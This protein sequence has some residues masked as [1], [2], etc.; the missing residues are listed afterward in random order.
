MAKQLNVNLAFTADTGKAAASIRSLQNQLT[1]LMNNAAK[2][3]A[4]LGLTKDI[5]EA[6]TA[7]AQLK[8]QL[9]GAMSSTGTLD[10]T[11][12]NDSLRASGMT[13]EQYRVK[14]SALGPEGTAAFSQLASSVASAEIPI[15][16]ANTLLTELGTTLA[17]TARWQLSSSLLHGFIGGLQHAY[18]YAQD[19][20]ES[21]NNI[22]IVTGQSTEQMA[23]LAQKAN[24]AAKELSTR[25]TDYTNASLI[26]YQQGLDDKAVEERTRTTLKLANVTRQSAEE[27]SSQ[28]TAIWN[29]F[30]DGSKKLEYYADAITALGAKTA[31]SSS[32]IAQGLS[33]FAAVADTIGL[34]YETASAAIATVVAE[35]RQSADTVGNAFK[36]IFARIESL[37]LGETLEDGVGLTKYTEALEK[38]GVQVLDMNG[39]L[40]DADSILSDLGERWNEISDT[41]KVAL[42]NT[43]AGQ[44][45]Y[46]QFVALFD[47]WDKVQ[48]NMGIVEDS[49]GTLQNQADIYAES[50]EASSKRVKASAEAIYDALLDDNFFIEFNNLLSEILDQ[51]NRLIKG[52]GG[53]GGTLTTLGALLTKVF[54]QQ[55]ASNIDRIVNNLTGASVKGAQQQQQEAIL[56]LQKQA[57][58]ARKSGSAQGFAQSE[59]LKAQA[60]LQETLIKNQAR[61]NEEQLKT[62]QNLLDQNNSLRQAADAQGELLDKT[63]K[64][65]DM[66]MKQTHAK[67]QLQ[68]QANGKNI[69]GIQIASLTDQETNLR[70]LINTIGQVE[71]E[72]NSFY[73]IIQNKSS[74]TN[75][76]IAEMGEMWNKNS[77][78]ISHLLGEAKVGS[79]AI[80]ELGQA[81]WSLDT[82]EASLIR[83]K[84][85]L[86]EVATQ[87]AQNSSNSVQD[88]AQSYTLLCG[89][90]DKAIVLVEELI[91]QFNKEE[92]V[93]TKLKEVLESLKNSTDGAADAMN[94]MKTQS[95]TFGQQVQA[96]SQFAMSFASVI[97]S[98]KS[99]IN[100]LN[101][102]DLS[103]GEKLLTIIPSLTM[104][105]SM[106]TASLTGTTGAALVTAASHI[107]LAGIFAANTV[108]AEGF[109]AA[110]LTLGS[111]LLAL[112]LPIAAIVGVGAGLIALFQYLSSNTPEAKLKAAKEA[113]EE[114]KTSL[115][116]AKTAAEDLQSAFDNYQSVRTELDNCTKGTDEWREALEK[117][118]EVVTNM[119]TDFPQL[120]Q[121]LELKDGALSLNEE[122][123][124]Q[125]QSLLNNR[126][127]GEQAVYAKKENEYYNL[128]NNAANRNGI[129]FAYQ[130]TSGKYMNLLGYTEYQKG[131]ESIS[132]QELQEG[133]KLLT[134][135]YN[136]NKDKSD[137]ALFDALFEAAQ[138]NAYNRDEN[139]FD[140]VSNDIIKAFSDTDAY[141][142]LILALENNSTSLN[143]ATTMQDKSNQAMANLILSKNQDFL[144]KEGAEDSLNAAGRVYGTNLNK[145]REFLDP[146]DTEN[147]KDLYETYTGNEV[148]SING[149]G[150][151]VEGIEDRIEVEDII[152]TIASIMS[153]DELASSMENLINA[154]NELYASENDAKI[155]L[156]DLFLG[157]DLSKS[158]NL[159]KEYGNKELSGE[160]K[161]TF[162]DAEDAAKKQLAIALDHILGDGDDGLLSEETLER[163]GFKSTADMVDAVYE[164]MQEAEDRIEDAKNLGNDY[165]TKISQERLNQNENYANLN[166]IQAEGAQNLIQRAI[167]GGGIDGFN[168]IL[169]ILSQSGDQIGNVIETL[170]SDDLD[171]STISVEELINQLAEIGPI[172]EE[173]AQTLINSYKQINELDLES[174]K[175]KYK[176]LHDIIDPLLTND[177]DKII[178]KEDYETLSSLGDKVND[179]IT[180]LADGTYKLTGDAQEFYNFI[181]EQNLQDFKAGI[182]STLGDINTLIEIQ[183]TKTNRDNLAQDAAQRDSKG[184]IISYDTKQAAN[185]VKFLNTLD[186]N[187]TEKGMLTQVEAIWEEYGGLTKT[188]LETLYELISNHVDEALNLNDTIDQKKQETQTAY[189]TTASGAKTYSELMDMIYGDNSPFKDAEGKFLE[190]FDSQAII[191]FW[192]DVVFDPENIQTTEQFKDALAN[193]MLPDSQSLKKAWKNLN[194]ADM[195]KEEI[196]SIMKDLKNAGGDLSSELVEG[197]QQLWSMDDSDDNRKAVLQNL[198]DLLHEGDISVKDSIDLYNEL[199]SIDNETTEQTIERLNQAI[200][201]GETNAQTYLDLLNAISSSKRLTDDQKIEAYQKNYNDILKDKN[202]SKEEKM[203]QFDETAEAEFSQ[204][205][206]MSGPIDNQIA[207]IEDLKNRYTAYLN[208]IGESPAPQILQ[209]MGNAVVDL[210][211]GSE[212]LTLDEKIERIKTE[213]E[214]AG[215]SLDHINE[216]VADLVINSDYL[217]LD[218][219]IEKIIEELGNTAALDYF[220]EHIKELL[221][222]D[223][224]S[225]LDQVEQ[226]NKLLAQ[227]LI[228]AEGYSKGWREILQNSKE[229]DAEE[230]QALLENNYQIKAPEVEKPKKEDYV[231]EAENGGKEFDQDGYQQALSAF[232]E[233]N[234]QALQ[235]FTRDYQYLVDTIQGSDFSS[236]ESLQRFFDDIPQGVEYINQARRAI[237]EYA[238]A[239]GVSKDLIDNYNYSVQLGNEEAITQNESQLLLAT[240]AQEIANAYDLESSSIQNIAESYLEL[241]QQEDSEYAYMKDRQD[242]ALAQ[243]QADMRINRG[244]E[245]LKENYDKNCEALDAL[246]KAVETNNQVEVE[247]VRTGKDYGKILSQMEDSLA[248]V[249]DVSKDLMKNRWMDDYLGKHPDQIKKVLNGDIDAIEEFKDAVADLQGQDIFGDAFDPEQLNKFQEEIADMD[250]G[251][252]ITPE[253]DTTG[254]LAALDEMYQQ[255]VITGNQIED[256]LSTLN[257]EAN[258]GD[259]PAGAEEAA[260]QTSDV[261][262]HI[263]DTAAA[264]GAAAGGTYSDS[265]AGNASINAG[266]EQAEFTNEGSIQD[267]QFTE[268]STVNYATYAADVLE[269][270]AKDTKTVHVRIPNV[271]QQVTATPVEEPT[272]N[273]TPVQRPTFEGATVKDNGKINAPKGGGGGGGRRGG[274]CFVAGT[275]ISTI[276][277]FKPIEDIQINDIVLSYNEILHRNEYSKVLETMIHIV[278]DKIYTLQIENEDIVCT[279]I[280]RFLITRYGKREWIEAQNLKIGDFVQFAD[281]TLHR[282]QNIDIEITIKVV[283]N[284]EV[285]GNHNYYVGK[286][287]ILAHNKGRRGGGGRGRTERAR[288]TRADNTVDKV[289]TEERYHALDKTL[290]KLNAQYDS[291]NKAKDLAFGKKHL[292]NLEKELGLQ[293]Q[294]YETNKQYLKQIKAYKAQDEAKI[295]SASGSNSLTYDYTKTTTTPGNAENQKKIDKL[296]KK[297]EKTKNSKKK[298]SYQKQIDQ[299][300]GSEA[301]SK[302][303][304]EQGATTIADFAGVA[305]VIENNVIQNIDQLYAGL[306]AAYNAAAEKYAKNYKDNLEYNGKNIAEIQ[307]NDAVKN[308]WEQAQAAYDAAKDAINQWEETVAKEQEKINEMLDNQ[309]EL[310]QL[311]LEKATYAVDIKLD[312]DDSKLDLLE[313]AM[314]RLGDSGRN[315][316][317]QIGKIGEKINLLTSKSKNN[318][319]GLANIISTIGTGVY[320]EIVDNTGTTQYFTK[321]GYTLNGQDVLSGLQ[322]SDAATRQAAISQL[323]SSKSITASQIEELTKRAKDQ[324][325][326]VKQIRETYYNAFEWIQSSMD[327]WN[328]KMDDII[329]KQNFLNGLMDHY[330]NV[331]DIIGST[332]IELARSTAI[333]G[334]EARKQARELEKTLEQNN[335]KRSEANLRTFREQLVAAE[336]MFEDISKRVDNAK[337]KLAQLR[338]QAMTDQNK[339]AIQEW[340]E[341]L[342]KYEEIQRSQQDKV[343]EITENMNSAFEEALQ[344]NLDSWTAAMDR[345]AEVFNERISGTAISIDYLADSLQRF[346]DTHS[347]YVAEYE[348]VHQ[349]RLMDLQAEKS[350][351]E[352]TNPKIRRELLEIQKEITASTAKD[353]E[354][355][356]YNLDY[357]RQ[358]LELKQAEAALEDAQKAKTQVSLNRD[359]E[360][361]F[362]YVYTAN[363]DDVAQA[364]QT[365]ADKIYEMQK[366]NAEYIQNL[367]SELV[368]ME[369]EYQQKMAEVAANTELSD[370]ERHRRLE[371]IN[372]DY[373][374]LHEALV[375][376][377]GEALTV[378]RDIY[379]KY[380]DQYAKITGDLTATNLAHIDSFE[381][382]EYAI[383]TGFVALDEVESAFRDA[384]QE[385][386]KDL[387]QA[388]ADYESNNAEVFDSAGK[389]YANFAEDV[390]DQTGEVATETEG[391]TKDMGTLADQAVDSFSTILSEVA[392]IVEPFV[393][394]M[395]EMEE[396]IMNLVEALAAAQTEM[397][398]LDEVAQNTGGG[399]GVQA[400]LVGL[401]GTDEIDNRLESTTVG[402]YRNRRKKRR[403]V[404]GERGK[405]VDQVK[406]NGLKQMRAYKDVV[407]RQKSSRRYQNASAARRRRMNKNIA[408]KADAA[409][410]NKLTSLLKK[411]KNVVVKYDTGGYTGDWD[412]KDGKMAMLHQKEL[413]LNKDDTQNILSAVGVMRDLASKIDINALASSG[414]FNSLGAAGVGAL[415]NELQQ[416]VE[417]E[418]NFPN[419]TSREEIQAAFENLIG[420][421]SQY[422]NR[423]AL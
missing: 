361:N 168:A 123:I 149:N 201:D 20:N 116:N 211:S 243:A 195:T 17:N 315:A 349:L 31:S 415:N 73:G 83:L 256:F 264:A 286:N 11:K 269:T 136:E 62:A 77:M 394:S 204:I 67:L 15:R 158:G 115:E 179:F 63:T 395:A 247:S 53:L 215:A 194:L 217:T 70:N 299:L 1:Q 340:E 160:Y 259:I 353:K 389:T 294:L 162:T 27:V 29:N 385:Y 38:V 409:A 75:S 12:F 311:R 360:G 40:R 185:Q 222:L 3:S 401:G 244:L 69:S 223:G 55:I 57:E 154:T 58:E 400:G 330:R 390:S 303:T 124:N 163:F 372:D 50:W 174:A 320:E 51:V 202:L 323:T 278:G 325:E 32:E 119:I 392:S 397:I 321:D 49:E 355:S 131:N 374:V 236:L 336:D 362:G 295:T 139:T 273:T 81:F 9:S 316:A 128:K 384:A 287:Q 43:V 268:S 212:S 292:E 106:L 72:L 213:G 74:L 408:K 59:G 103:I 232:D 418:A 419:A 102:E 376:Q 19:L 97:N 188:G 171:Y 263:P 367:Q 33:K 300:A 254:F 134:E 252:V 156:A 37:K 312:I 22:R 153:S 146:N 218:E 64:Q 203:T 133:F 197:L 8:A 333:N 184:N 391:L 404:V 246:N 274:G 421:A 104:S 366:A 155:G 344:A 347:T 368:A 175:E 79:D 66:L 373:N 71:S 148:T 345:A 182:Q 138:T 143:E 198:L 387:E 304:T 308:E 90:S 216:T 52:F 296:N 354:M 326:I 189:Q 275:L 88:L 142:D 82:S 248:D 39:N 327:Y 13:L 180:P 21:L 100:T 329:N 230:K 190:G 95:L 186:L 417:I 307:A 219:K 318:L 249:L 5:K 371:A 240:G 221:N 266:V 352:A 25:T 405:S 346:T 422:A 122:G 378:S 114:Q 412:G 393:G 288:L 280:H 317:A 78:A 265:F 65:T 210:I 144:S 42:A 118:N 227:G 282:I 270:N 396:A 291:I 350:I 241:A 181:K 183:K 170:N 420:L 105:F 147:L 36:S 381:D 251:D 406:R 48:E 351:N 342:E 239:I 379:G 87:M 47:N 289:K 135:A 309:I 199:T 284:F 260:A 363:S 207:A 377:F 93:A 96:V 152:E 94:K 301:Q 293:K 220:N 150:F 187:E 172:S 225:T 228:N 369:Q 92:A 14:L 141:A 328:N 242:L 250:I 205:K 276:N 167:Q 237:S 348:K 262:S 305:P 56:A 166:A 253:I 306:D 165:L 279:G 46:A 332:R 383:E 176:S 35:T 258:W 10:L 335:K 255:G 44:R 4:S 61:Y 235:G 357:L 271:Q 85:A 334:Q 224:G 132:N 120:K 177:S 54:S 359:N 402:R 196:Q 231:H 261:L 298:A 101:D 339:A 314:E 297:I 192:K 214:A 324:L 76:E 121:Y 68:A 34:S 191:D 399:I 313:F 137:E 161:G 226:L 238:D 331:V 410:R 337:Q 112:A 338:N 267:A 281:G 245:D 84:N 403:V 157:K 164:G 375:E 7:V 151:K 26:Y 140:A 302:T 364:E 200:K 129:D 169:D 229:Y 382:T 6:T 98:I 370:E 310:V 89:S 411:Y 159:I 80:L 358:K 30:D 233:A 45:Q 16:R 24:Q 257:L 23:A 28:M 99:A 113:L 407:K 145:N 423:S 41:Q 234:A 283:Y 319:E 365:Y 209:E 290:D 127:I 107:P 18:G 111:S 126:I 125:Y 2:D 356:Q 193:G 206:S 130:D 322:S 110:S 380:S 277:G 416:H 398:S 388:E 343:Y 341:T 108:A 413:V 60:T 386:M 285:D 86:K 117:V 208:T 173:Q 272:S 178:K 91:A 109:S 414:A